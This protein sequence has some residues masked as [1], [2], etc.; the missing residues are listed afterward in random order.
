MTLTK[1]NIMYAYNLARGCRQFDK[2]RLNRAFG[3]LMSK[4]RDA[5][6]AKYATSMKSC[7]CGDSYRGT[8][9]CKHRIAMMI[10]FRAEHPLAPDWKEHRRFFE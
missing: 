3:I 5:R 1:K 2:A 8:T 10:I 6:L 7:F 9:I 4:D